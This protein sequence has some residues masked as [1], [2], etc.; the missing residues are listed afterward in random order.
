MLEV[1]RERDISS[2]V[3][4]ALFKKCRASVNY[5]TSE[6]QSIGKLNATTGECH[7]PMQ[8][9]EPSLGNCNCAGQAKESDEHRRRPPQRYRQAQTA[10]RARPT[11]PPSTALSSRYVAVAP[12]QATAR[13]LIVPM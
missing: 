5:L 1:T 11:P 8:I 9:E 7:A 6:R 2:R 12:R 3:A 13:F 10:R 4:R